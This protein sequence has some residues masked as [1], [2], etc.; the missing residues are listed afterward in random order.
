MATADLEAAQPAVAQDVEEPVPVESMVAT[1]VT[2]ATPVAAVDVTE[3]GPVAAAHAEPNG[4]AAAAG[5]GEVGPGAAADEETANRRFWEEFQRRRKADR[6]RRGPMRETNDVQRLLEEVQR[7]R[8]DGGA[9]SSKGSTACTDRSLRN[10]GSEVQQLLHDVRQERKSSSAG[11]PTPPTTSPIRER[12]PQSHGSGRAPV[13]PPP[14]AAL[15]RMQQAELA[16]ECSRAASSGGHSG[17][18]G[19]SRRGNS[20]GRPR[21]RGSGS[22]GAVVRGGCGS[23]GACTQARA[24]RKPLA[25]KAYP[26]GGWD[27]RTACGTTLFG[28]YPGSILRPLPFGETA[29]G[30][31]R[32]R[33]P[34]GKRK[35]KSSKPAWDSLTVTPKY[36]KDLDSSK[37]HSDEKKTPEK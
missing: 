22:A 37:P 5:A 35:A 26:C 24:Q 15:R 9:G 30:G 12:S 19:G 18:A 32:S 33:S 21:G 20:T 36:F 7:E 6:E 25:H 10:K 34:E 1:N 29:P 3:A 17:M 16:P 14:P 23:I 31:T 28:P 11:S 2:G 27:D 8:A 4:H 13:S